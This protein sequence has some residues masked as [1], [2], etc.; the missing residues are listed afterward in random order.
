MVMFYI[1]YDYGWYREPY[2]S[3]SSKEEAQKHL[4]K[5]NRARPGVKVEIVQSH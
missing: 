1:V 3:Y 4:F 5:A 2:C